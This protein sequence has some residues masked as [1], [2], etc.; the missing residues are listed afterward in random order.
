VGLAQHRDDAVRLTQL[1]GAE[2]DH[3]VAIRRHA[4]ILAVRGDTGG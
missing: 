3:L 4:T 1:V 2:D